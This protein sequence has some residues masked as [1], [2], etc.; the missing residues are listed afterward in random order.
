MVRHLL[1]G[2]SFAIL[3]FPVAATTLNFQHMESSGWQKSSD[4]SGVIIEGATEVDGVVQ[5]GTAEAGHFRFGGLGVKSD[6]DSGYS[7]G[8]EQLD[9][10]GANDV[11]VFRFDRV[12][13]LDRL[14]FTLGDYWDR[15][16]LYLGESLT[17]QGTYKVDDLSGSHWSSTILLGSGFESTTFAIGASEYTSC[18]YDIKYGHDCWTENSAFRLSSLTFSE[19]DQPAVLQAVPIPAAFLLL[20]SS[21]LGLFT[22]KKYQ[23][24]ELRNN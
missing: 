9:T 4:V 23:C 18:G 7:D 20:L 3:A 21:I 5:R 13:S 2:F 15:F 6:D 12:V 10:Q 11:A 22:L 16:D 24:S 17:Y 8:T 19:I 1:L 14:S